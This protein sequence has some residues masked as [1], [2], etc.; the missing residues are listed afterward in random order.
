MVFKTPFGH[1]GAART[2]LGMHTVILPKRRAD[3]VEGILKERLGQDIIEDGSSFSSFYSK[4]S[5]YFSGKNVSF[6]DLIDVEGASD[7]EKRVWSMAAA[8]PWGQ[9]RS[10]DW[11]ARSIG[12]PGA[13]RAVGR[14]L[15]CNR[16]PII[17][18]C[19]RVTKK[20]GDIGG[21]ADGPQMKSLLLKIEGSLH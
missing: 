21:F 8:I 20:D 16:L 2:R 5:E 19:H 14:A 7:F 12:Q 18:P 1:M 3:E 4:T 17:I 10:Y 11:V 13:Y 15:A 6:D 9:V